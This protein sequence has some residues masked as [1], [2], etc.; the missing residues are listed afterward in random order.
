MSIDIYKIISFPDNEDSTIFRIRLNPQHQIYEGHFPEN[1]ITPGVVMLQILKEL[2]Q[3]QLQ[4]KLCLYDASNVKFL[5]LVNP[6]REN[7]L[8]FTFEISEI[9]KRYR[10]KNTTTFP[11]GRIVLKCNATFVDR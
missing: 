3:I 7:E 8:I 2:T 5:Q 10:I 11:D 1:P 6:T 4:K 9:E